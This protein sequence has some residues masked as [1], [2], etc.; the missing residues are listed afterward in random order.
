[1]PSLTACELTHLAIA[2]R[3]AE[4][5]LLYGRNLRRVV[6]YGLLGMCHVCHICRHLCQ[7]LGH[8]LREGVKVQVLISVAVVGGIDKTVII[9]EME[10]ILRLYPTTVLLG[11]DSLYEC[12][13]LCAVGIEVHLLLCAVQHLHVDYLRVG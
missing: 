7:S 12:T 6:V 9:N 11:Q 8:A 10:R 3:E 2:E 1:M 13:A 5:V 4:E